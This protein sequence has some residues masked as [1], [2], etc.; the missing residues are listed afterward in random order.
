MQIVNSTPCV[1]EAIPFYGP[2]NTPVLT[3]MVK[4]TFEIIDGK[5]AVSAREQIP[6]AFGDDLY[7]NGTVKFESDLAPFK[8]RADIVLV[9]NAHAP[10][11]KPVQILDVKLRVGD[12]RKI[13]R[14]FGDRTWKPSTLLDSELPTDPRPFKT[15][16]LVYEKAFG[17]IDMHHGGFCEENPVGIGYVSP[18]AKKIKEGTAL[19]NIEDPGYL[20]RA[21]HDR[22]KPV[23]FGFYGKTW[24]PR[25]R[26]L[27][28]YDE[29]WRKERSPL[30]PDDFSF[31]FYNA[32]HPDLQVQGYLRGDET[33]ELVNLSREGKLDFQLPSIGL[34]CLVK[35]QDEPDPYA[36]ES[37]WVTESVVMNI[38]TLCILPDVK[39]FYLTW[40]GLCPI[41][42][43]SAL[44]VKNVLIEGR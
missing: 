17:G 30:P 34:S 6:L 1:A 21:V 33:V 35:K 39:R 7:A 5:T 15:M 11:G 44:E 43:L 12:T 27:G 42:D 9:G 18:G 14:I 40:R 41:R 36:D 4:G 22:P 24:M 20:I 2:G 13:L 10:G 19:P 32:A 37:S 26:Y 8:P 3:V 16:P 23:G 31:D 28:T 38:D 29:K 25:V